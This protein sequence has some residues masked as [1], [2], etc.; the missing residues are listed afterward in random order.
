M[1]RNTGKVDQTIRIIIGI[2]IISLGIYF[3]SW[4][5]AIG[6]IPLITAALGFCPLY[7]P[8]KIN[9]YKK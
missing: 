6:L 9:T 5:G 7:E 1:K 8:L 4:W 3:K 2:V